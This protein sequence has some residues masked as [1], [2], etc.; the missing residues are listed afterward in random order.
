MVNSGPHQFRHGV[1]DPWPDNLLKP[2]GFAMV[3]FFGRGR[4]PLKRHDMAGRPP[5][6]AVNV[7][8]LNVFKGELPE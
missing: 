5:L 3:R 1:I 6:D 2:D 8:R 4:K 7:K